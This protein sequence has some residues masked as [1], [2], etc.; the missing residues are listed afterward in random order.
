M[1]TITRLSVRTDPQP[2]IEI[3]ND[4]PAQVYFAAQGKERMPMRAK[5]AGR[6]Y[7]IVRYLPDADEMSHIRAAIIAIS[8]STIRN[9]KTRG[10]LLIYLMRLFS[11]NITRSE[12]SL[13]KIRT[14]V[15]KRRSVAH[16]R[17]G[18]GYR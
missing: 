2:A 16:P 6:M 12:N 5:R 9:A 1:T 13:T 15:T 18:N 8:E 14:K 10:M 4:V 7:P 11:S 3:H 17:F